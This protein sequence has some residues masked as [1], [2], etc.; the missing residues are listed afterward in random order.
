MTHFLV[1]VLIASLV[2]SL[3]CAGMCGPFMAIVA[4]GDGGARARR[5]Q[6][7]FAYHFGR[8]VVYAT[9]GALF[10]LLGA[11]LDLGAALAGVQRVAAVLAGALMLAMGVVGALRAGG[12]RLVLLGRSKAPGPLTRLLAAAHRRLA[13]WPAVPRALLIGLLTTLLPCGWLYAFALVAAGSASAAG[14][15]ATMIAFWLGTVPILAALGV[16]VQRLS[17]ALGGRLPLA[18]SLLVAGIGLWTVIYRA[19]HPLPMEFVAQAAPRGI[20]EAAQRAAALDSESMPCC[21][22]EKE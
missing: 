7:H 12:A 14:G 16:G 11:A 13:V 9:I 15:A 18:M 8:L 21:H 17:A 2:G 5:W 10:G 19:Q 6:C 3:H 4:G 1:T 20:A 22:G